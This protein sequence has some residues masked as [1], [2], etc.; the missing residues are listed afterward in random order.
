MVVASRSC[1]IPVVI[2]ALALT[3]RPAAAPAVLVASAE[4]ARHE[5]SPD[6]AFPWAHTGQRGDFSAVY[7]GHRWVLTAAHV[8]AAPVR[9]NGRSFRPLPGSVQSM[10][11][12]DGSPSDLR[13]FR[14]DG[15][16]GL[17]MLPIGRERPPTGSHLILVGNGHDRGAATLWR[18][19][20]RPPVPG[21][22]RG[23][24]RRVRW[25]T[26][27]LEAQPHEIALGGL[28]TRVLAMTFS[29]RD[30][31]GATRDESQAV[32]GD[33]GGGVFLQEDGRFLLVGIIIVRADFPGQPPATTLHGNQTYAAD[34]SAYRG[35]LIALTRPD[36]AD[37]RD[38]DDDGA[39]D[40][41]ADAGCP[42]PE[43]DSE[44]AAAPG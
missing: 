20:G 23:D 33:S 4:D 29:P 1:F 30:A 16:P 22:Q 25:G 9:F 8:G 17:G 19:P 3:W 11:N 43:H 26:N 34:L 42:R 7:L 18:P 10:R 36:C 44:R 13:A 37:E 15:D 41:P 6:P 12:P 2:A 28:R 40:F 27:R 31:P 21:W 14:I 5:V 39:V 38:N 35:Q 24:G 32:R